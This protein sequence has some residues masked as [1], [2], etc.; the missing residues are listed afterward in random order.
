MTPK[1]AYHEWHTTF[2]VPSTTSFD[3]TGYD[4]DIGSVRG[5]PQKRDVFN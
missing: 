2:E 4:R 5:L 3:Q 1:L